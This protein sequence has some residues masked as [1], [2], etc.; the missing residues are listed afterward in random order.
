MHGLSVQR[1]GTESVVLGSDVHV[2]RPQA[3]LSLF[4]HLKETELFNA[5]LTRSL[6]QLL[7]QRSCQS[8]VLVKRVIVWDHP[9]SSSK[10]SVRQQC[11][12]CHVACG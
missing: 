1:A 9:L 10:V 8:M 6:N 11:C 5:T 12:H 4:S 2:G 3:R 7:Y